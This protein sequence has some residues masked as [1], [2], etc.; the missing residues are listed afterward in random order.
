L[1]RWASC[2]SPPLFGRQRYGAVNGALAA[3]VLAS[4][5][6]GPLVAAVIWSAKG[7]YDAVILTLTV[8]GPLSAVIFVLAL[9]VKVWHATRPLE[10]P[11]G[12]Q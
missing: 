7:G 5:A 1:K 6:F 3:P 12:M 11:A 8:I 2:L 10:H 9:K 4:R